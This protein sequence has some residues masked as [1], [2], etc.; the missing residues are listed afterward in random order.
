MMKIFNFLKNE[1]PPKQ[2]IHHSHHCC[3]LGSSSNG[4]LRSNTPFGSYLRA[5]SYFLPAFLYISEGGS[6]LC[7]VNTKIRTTL[8]R[9]IRGKVNQKGQTRDT[10]F[11]GMREGVTEPICITGLRRSCSRLG[12]HTGSGLDPT[13]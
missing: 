9:S 11:V 5:A 1:F 2:S 12:M 7:E 4:G 10:H 8:N 6:N 3:G 13:P